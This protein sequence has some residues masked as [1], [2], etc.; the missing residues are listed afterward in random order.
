MV[1]RE[2]ILKEDRGGLRFSDEIEEYILDENMHLKAVRLRNGETID[3]I[4][5]HRQFS[6]KHPLLRTPSGVRDTLD[7]FFIHE[8]RERRLTAT[9]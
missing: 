8:F 7:Q 1:N 4:H 3:H 9:V 2:S 5:L 6:P